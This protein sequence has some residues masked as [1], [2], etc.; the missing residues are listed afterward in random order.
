MIETADGR[1]R[2]AREV[3]EDAALATL[4]IE[5]GPLLQTLNMLQS[6][7]RNNEERSRYNE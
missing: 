2:W 6:N 3:Y 5:A 1:A 4:L 7:A